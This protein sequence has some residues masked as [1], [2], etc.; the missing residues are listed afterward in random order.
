VPE[1]ANFHGGYR[2]PNALKGFVKVN[3][4][5]PGFAQT[6][7]IK[8]DRRAFSYWEI[9]TSSWQVEHGTYG[10]GV[11]SSSRDFRLEGEITI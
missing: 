10:I 4:L 11:A 7:D 6:V 9:Q 5:E 2:S 1:T 3:D 8:L